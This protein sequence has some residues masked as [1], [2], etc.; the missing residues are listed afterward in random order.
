MKPLIPVRSNLKFLLLIGLI[1]IFSCSDD[2]NCEEP[3][4][5]T[6]VSLCENGFAGEYPCSGYD[7][8]GHIPAETLGGTGA[9]AND[10]WGWTDPTTGKEYALIG[11][12]PGIVFVDI[13]NTENLI[14]VGRLP[15]ATVNSSWR[16]VK[17][18]NNYAFIVSEAMGHGMQVFDLT[19]LRNVT[20]APETFSEDAHYS[21][22]GNAHNIVINA[23]SGYAYAVGTN[24][25]NGGAHFVNIQNP[26]NP[27]ETGGLE[28]GGYSHDAQVITYNGP[29][30]DYT[31]KEILIGSNENEVVLADISDKS[32]PVIISTI[33]YQNIGYTHQG[34]FTD[35]FKYFIVGDETD[36][37]DFG[38]NTRT[39]IFDFTDLDN[40]VLH[41]T[42]TGTTSAIDHNGY[43]KDN[44]YYMANYRAGV[45]FIDISDLENKS[46]QEIGFF[47]T[48]P[49]NDNADFDGVWNVYPYFE[50]G[51]IIISDIE[52]GLFIVR[53]S[54]T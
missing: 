22:F 48:Y 40:P 24:T 11:M 51:N 5:E 25:Y 42:Y 8:M 18:Y 7:L 14:I 19:R 26:L 35:N 2:C 27:V 36:E 34:W 47:D 28:A 23:D 15:T 10:S 12:T 13:S 46:M 54:R 43:V 1:T 16:D 4:E 39:L 45:R 50:S 44:T 53:K 30:S 6:A 32:N 29:D 33:A 31:G 38:G 9:K 52:G 17:V 49:N 3:P 41:H 37:I 21:E 20:N